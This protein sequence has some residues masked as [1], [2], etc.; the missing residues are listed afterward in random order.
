MRFQ[1]DFED[2]FEVVKS[3]Q[4]G[5]PNLTYT[6]ITLGLNT[7][8]YHVGKFAGSSRQTLIKSSDLLGY[9]L[10]GCQHHPKVSKGIYCLFELFRSTLWH[11]LT[12]CMEQKKRKLNKQKNK[13]KFQLMLASS[14]IG[15]CS[16][17]NLKFSKF[18]VTNVSAVQN[19]LRGDPVPL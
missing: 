18:T 17:E 14:T 1:F 19:S 9:Y 3:K 8:F 12:Q 4:N 6:L 7:L 16:L 10:N 13:A 11:Q 5:N 15:I 2:I